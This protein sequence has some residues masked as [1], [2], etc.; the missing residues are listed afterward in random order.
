MD[1]DNI[2]AACRTVGGRSLQLLLLK[3]NS[4]GC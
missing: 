3:K 4:R 1:A 2:V